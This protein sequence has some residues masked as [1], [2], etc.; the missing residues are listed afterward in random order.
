M[1]TQNF[2]F[3]VVGNS[4]KGGGKS[5][6]ISVESTCQCGHSW[7]LLSVAESRADRFGSG[8]GSREWAVVG[9]DEAHFAPRLCGRPWLKFPLRVPKQRE[10]GAL[11]WPCVS[12]MVPGHLEL[13][14][15]YFIMFNFRNIFNSGYEGLPGRSW[16]WILWYHPAPRWAPTASPQ[17]HPGSSL[18]VSPVPNTVP[19]VCVKD[20]AG[21]ASLCSAGL[22]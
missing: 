8:R 19:R 3:L 6:F 14:W 17:S 21:L 12:L 2:I 15:L 16:D 13:S 11:A 7:S 22:V 9:K 4:A 20:S 1:K 10:A 5:A 18:Q